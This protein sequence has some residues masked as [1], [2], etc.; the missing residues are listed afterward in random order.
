[1]AEALWR[2]EAGSRWE[3]LSAGTAPKP[4]HPMTLQ[5][6][7]EIGVDTSGLR[8]K[9]LSEVDATRLDLLV[10]VCDQARENCP[11]LPGI[12]AQRHW[13][14][15]DPAAAQGTEEERLAVFRRIRDQ[16]HRYV[17]EFLASSAGQ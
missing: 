6:L 9:H 4:V 12:G 11:V 16:I 17:R 15:E 5:V 13:S 10:T 7:Q 1:M 14:L 3:V 8:S 2:H